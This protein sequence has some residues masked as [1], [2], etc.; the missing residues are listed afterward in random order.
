MFDK[1]TVMWEM[2]KVAG[3][4]YEVRHGG[5]NK[6]IDAMERF[7]NATV[8]HEEDFDDQDFINDWPETPAAMIRAFLE[9]VYNG[10]D[11]P[12]WLEKIER[13]KA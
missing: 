4:L 2:L 8:Y 9:S 13:S 1:L 6:L 11:T 12:R 3:L 5:P 7:N 10:A